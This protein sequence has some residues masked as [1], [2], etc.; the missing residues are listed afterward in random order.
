[1]TALGAALYHDVALADDTQPIEARLDALFAGESGL[2]QFCVPLAPRKERPSA[3]RREKLLA[4][5][6]RG[7]LASFLVETDEGERDRVNNASSVRCR[8]ARL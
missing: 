1:M 4:R 3:F 5:V 6:K 7:E 8:A 2:E